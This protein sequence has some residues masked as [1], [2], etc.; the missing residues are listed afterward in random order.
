MRKYHRL[1]FLRII[2]IYPQKFKKSLVS[3]DTH[4]SNNPSHMCRY[5]WK[6]FLKIKRWSIL[7]CRHWNIEMTHLCLLA[8]NDGWKEIFSFTKAFEQKFLFEK[9]S[10]D[11]AHTS[12]SL[13]QKYFCCFLSHGMKW[14]FWKWFFLRIFLFIQHLAPLFLSENLSPDFDNKKGEKLAYF[15]LLFNLRARVA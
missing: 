2:I 10:H 5:G 13:S 15:T 4:L 1:R 11:D 8:I 6:V 9:K 3:C 14:K 7:W 12:G